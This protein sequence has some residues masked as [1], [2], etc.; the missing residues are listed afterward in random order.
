MMTAFPVAKEL[1]MSHDIETALPMLGHGLFGRLRRDAASEWNDY[2]HHPFVRGLGEGTLSADVFRTFLVQDYLYILQYA[3]AYALV[4]Y[5]SNT[6]AQMRSA[7]A[8]VSGLLSMEVK[9]HTEFCTGWG[10]SEAELEGAPESLELLAYSRYLLDRAHAGDVLDLMVALSACL[11]G[12]GEIGA[13]LMADPATRREG[14]PYLPWI[15]TYGGDGYLAIAAEG[16]DKLDALG[17][18]L[19]AQARYPLLLKQFRMT[20]RLEAS[21]W[22]AGQ[23]CNF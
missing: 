16:I 3:R 4:I 23:T 17:T 2:V 6:L 7:A 18:M 5:K 21:F 8:V 15:E 12:Y 13:R 11:V 20:V 14:N 10:L 22:N 19:G 1:S 9:M